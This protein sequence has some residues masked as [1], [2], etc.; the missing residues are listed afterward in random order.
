MALMT[1]PRL[2]LALQR[3]EWAGESLGVYLFRAIEDRARPREG[4]PHCCHA[5]R[6]VSDLVT[7]ERVAAIPGW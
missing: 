5:K 6:N 1:D 2:G 4:Q 7:R 3:R